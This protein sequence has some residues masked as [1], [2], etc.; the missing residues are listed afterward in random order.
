MLKQRPEEV[1]EHAQGLLWYRWL[2]SGEPQASGAWLSR[3]GVMRGE[4]VQEAGKAAGY[5]RV[6]HML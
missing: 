6:L 3:T 4:R 2:Q 1:R 5:H